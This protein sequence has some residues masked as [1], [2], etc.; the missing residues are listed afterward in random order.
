MP[1]FK[2]EKNLSNLFKVF[3]LENCGFFGKGTIHR[4]SMTERRNQR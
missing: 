3:D 2:A 4:L 1:K